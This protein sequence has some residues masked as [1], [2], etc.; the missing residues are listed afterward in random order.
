MTENKKVL[1]PVLM[2]WCENGSLM[3]DYTITE[4]IFEGE[5]GLPYFVSAIRSQ[6]FC[7]AYV[8]E[9][10]FYDLMYYSAEAPA[11][12]EDF[13]T[14]MEAHALEIVELALDDNQDPINSDY[15]EE[16]TLVMYMNDCYYKNNTL[17][18]AEYIEKYKN[19]ELSVSFP[20][21]SE[22]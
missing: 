16:L 2:R 8:S 14:R 7:T 18:A 10:S 22:W 4:I 17:N 12:F 15:S 19:N 3:D 20:T 1:N 13:R 21:S 9:V 6:I 11:A 5:D